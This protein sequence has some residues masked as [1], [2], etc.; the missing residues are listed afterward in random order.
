MAPTSG[1]VVKAA[2]DE[3]YTEPDPRIDLSGKDVMRKILILARE[4]GAV[5]EM[6]DIKNHSFLPEE[7]LHAKDVPA[8]YEQLDVH[9]AHFQQLLRSASGQR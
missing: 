1:E 4:S 5:L 3:G 7:C 8:F 9:A 6:E 2:Q